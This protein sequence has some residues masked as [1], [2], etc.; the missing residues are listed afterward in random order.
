MKRETNYY[1]ITEN[2]QSC[3]LYLHWHWCNKLTRPNQLTHR[4]LF[5]SIKGKS[6][7]ITKLPNGIFRH[8]TSLRHNQ[9]IVCIVSMFCNEWIWIKCNNLPV[10][11]VSGLVL[12]V[13]TFWWVFRRSALLNVR[14]HISHLKD[15]LTPC[16]S[17]WCLFKTSLRLNVFWHWSQSKLFCR[18]FTMLPS[19]P[20]CA[21]RWVFMW[22]SREKHFP[23]MSQTDPWSVFLCWVRTCRFRLKARSKVASQYWQWCCL[24]RFGAIV[25]R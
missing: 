10:L 12:F 3:R 14:W 11:D 24:M 7:I 20:K 17:R 4:K 19:P 25:I 15:L 5:T 9:L 6:I 21:F 8:V 22:S 2:N 1:V 18:T 16:C 23:Q 13:C